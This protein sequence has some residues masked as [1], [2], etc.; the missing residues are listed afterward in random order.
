MGQRILDLEAEL[1]RVR[2]TLVESGMEVSKVRE[3]AATMRRK[4]VEHSRQD[5]V[6]P[7]KDEVRPGK[8]E[9][10]GESRER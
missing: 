3:E 2:G 9:G 10:S 5:Q 4:M 7:G 8:D 1:A 6:R